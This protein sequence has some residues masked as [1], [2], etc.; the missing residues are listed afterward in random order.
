MSYSSEYLRSQHAPLLPRTLPSARSHRPSRPC[1]VASKTAVGR[2]END[3]FDQ[4]AVCRLV[5]FRQVT[6]VSALVTSKERKH[7]DELEERDMETKGNERKRNEVLVVL[8]QHQLVYG[9][10]FGSCH[11]MSLFTT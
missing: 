10:D 3:R 1:P 6:G 11:L 5:L 2:L 4:T 9:K 8:V 7:M